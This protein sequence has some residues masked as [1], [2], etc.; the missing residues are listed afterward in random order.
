MCDRCEL[1]FGG[2]EALAER[3]DPCGA[4][5]SA[6]KRVGTPRERVLL[7]LDFSALYRVQRQRRRPA[8][9]RVLFKQRDSRLHSGAVPEAGSGV[10]VISQAL[11]A[12]ESVDV[13]VE[14][15]GQAH[16]PGL[17]CLAR[18]RGVERRFG[19]AAPRDSSQAHG[20][21]YRPSERATGAAQ[22]GI[23]PLSPVSVI[24]VIPG[25]RLLARVEGAAVWVPSSFR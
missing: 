16:V 2:A 10:C 15:L 21:R 22:F 17:E 24:A 23:W 4:V 18:A 13:H 8:K 9:P 19:S 5:Q 11:V 7:A 20:Y 6:P 3:E 25:Y 1:R 12:R 14:A